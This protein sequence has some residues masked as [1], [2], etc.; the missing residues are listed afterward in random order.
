M[1][2][3]RQIPARMRSRD[4]GRDIAGAGLVGR[5]KASEISDIPSP[6]EPLGG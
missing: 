1:D 3:D 5:R 6:A 4:F 2:R